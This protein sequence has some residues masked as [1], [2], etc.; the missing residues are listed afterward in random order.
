V[1]PYAKNS[2]LA[3]Y[4]S[5]SVHGA[6]DEADP[7]RMVLML[8][9]AVMERL[10]KVRGCIERGEIVQRTKMLHSCVVLIGELRGSLNLDEGGELAQNLSSL[11]EYMV[12]RLLLANLKGDLAIVAEITSLMTEIRDAWVAIGPEVRKSNHAVAPA[13]Q[14][15]VAAHR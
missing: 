13:A 12:R 3:A 9:S 10:A 7:H 4:Q 15:G 8:M 1:S 6:V 5:V 2:Q 11:Y 14:M